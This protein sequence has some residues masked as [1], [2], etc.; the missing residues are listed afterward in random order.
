MSAISSMPVEGL[1]KTPGNLP[2]P[3]CPDL[4]IYL[5][6]GVLR[7]KDE[8]LLGNAFMG[9][10]VE[11]ESSFLFFSCPSRERVKGLL[12]YCPDLELDEDYHFSYDEWQGGGVDVLEIGPFV[13][14]P[15]WLKNQPDNG[16]IEILL[17]PGVVF[18]N[19]L[20]IPLREIV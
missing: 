1:K 8:E 19:C 18:G 2:S 13:I 9:N 5:M 15:P 12:N 17:D 14:V 4:Y 3:P 20:C 6:K 16:A 11:G 10:W 7:E